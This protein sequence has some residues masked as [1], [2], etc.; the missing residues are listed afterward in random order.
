MGILLSPVSVR[1]RY[2][3]HETDPACRSLQHR[4]SRQTMKSVALCRFNR[5]H[6]FYTEGT[7]L[8]VINK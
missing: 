5:T 7:S 4:T 6:V 8:G 3:T 1:E 2:E